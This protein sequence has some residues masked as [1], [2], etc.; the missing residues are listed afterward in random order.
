MWWKNVEI[1]T[2]FGFSYCYC[3]YYR[4][5]CYYY[6]YCCCCCWFMYF[7]PFSL[8]TILYVGSYRKLLSLVEL[9]YSSLLF[10]LSIPA[11]LHSIQQQGSSGIIIIIISDK[12]ILTVYMNNLTNYRVK[13]LHKINFGVFIFTFWCICI[14][15]E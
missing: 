4:C 2:D 3:C 8:L 1:V 15:V 13:T 7:W 5:Y 14:S 10:Y 9:R 12:K 6:C 11:S